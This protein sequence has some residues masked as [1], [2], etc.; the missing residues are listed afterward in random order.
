MMP[1]IEKIDNPAQNRILSTNFWTIYESKGKITIPVAVVDYEKI[2]A[3]DFYKDYII[4]GLGILGIVYSFGT[5]IISLLLGGYRLISRKTVE[6][7]D[8]TWKVWNLLTS[9]GNLAV[10]LNLLMIM[11]PLMS[12]D[13]DSLAPWRYMLFAALGLLLT[14]A[15]LLPLFRKSR[16]KLSKGRLFLT[17]MT[18][19]SALAVVANILYW[20]LYQW[21]VL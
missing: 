10:P 14:A 9:L 12:D 6:R 18:S 5:L 16:E 20:S 3:F 17:A 7:T 13:L 19:L 21:W 11:I 15:A 1:S 4:L 2:S 8:R